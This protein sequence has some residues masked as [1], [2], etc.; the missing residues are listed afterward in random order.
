MKRLLREPL[1]QFLA[2]GLGLFVLFGVVNR[3]GRRADPKVITVDRDAL[4]TFIQY[5]I[6][7]FDPT[8]AEQKLRSLSDEELQRLVDDYVREEVLHR[9][10]LALGL[11]EDDYVIRR[12][13]VQKLEFITE[14]FA[15]ASIDLDDAALRR[16][17]DANKDDYYVEPYVTFT[18]VFF[19]AEK[20]PRA[21][22]QA[23]AERKLEALN[24]A[25][26]HFSDAPKHGDRFLYH[27]NY[28]ERTPDYVRSHFGPAMTRAIFDMEP[29]DLVWRG[30]FDSPYGVHLVLLV[31][32]EPGREPELAEIEERVREDARQAA[33]RRET[34][35]AIAEIV[36]AYEIRITYEPNADPMRTVESGRGP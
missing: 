3:D 13:L 36:D 28:V 7:A 30:P 31:T 21:E 23:L 32:N 16:H 26:T 24:R 10:A 34:E 27:V 22:A 20:R 25:G 14:G 2:A 18:H 1:V 9:E 15:E 29:N 17:F 19:D 35:A 11:D 12:R 4:M 33:I 5:R 8:M 6:K